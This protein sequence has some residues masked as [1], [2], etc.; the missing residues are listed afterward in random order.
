MQRLGAKGKTCVRTII[1]AT[2]QIESV[3]PPVQITAIVALQNV[4]SIRNELFPMALAVIIDT[5]SVI[6]QNSVFIDK[7]RDYKI[8]INK[9]GY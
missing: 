4:L 8:E 5:I 2:R 9:V 1:L 6:A 3:K 7:K